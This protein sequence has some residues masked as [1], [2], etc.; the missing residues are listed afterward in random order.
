VI[1]VVVF[2]ASIAVPFLKLLTLFYLVATV[3]LRSAAWRRQRTWIFHGLELI[4]PWAMLD[5][6]VMA[7]LVALVKLGELA[8]VLPGRGLFSFTAVAVLTMLASTSFDP[9]L[10]WERR[11]DPR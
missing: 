8:T 3:K 5:V 6:F 9:R 11:E 1:G 10:I 4:G 7:V 2:L